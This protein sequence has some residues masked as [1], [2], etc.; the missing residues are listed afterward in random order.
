MNTLCKFISVATA[1]Y[2]QATIR[3]KMPQI[4]K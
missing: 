4:P 2:M 3:I 1:S